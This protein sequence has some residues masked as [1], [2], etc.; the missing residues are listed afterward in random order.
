MCSRLRYGRL[1]TFD[2]GRG[3]STRAPAVGQLLN[4]GRGT[5]PAKPAPTWGLKLADCR[6]AQRRAG[7]IPRQ[8]R[9]A[10][11]TGVLTEVAVDIALS[12]GG[13]PFVPEFVMVTYWEDEALVDT[14]ALRNEPDA[15]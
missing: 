15:Q 8:S 13:D 12:S 5:S 4:E 2:K 7:N 10:L 3:K 6:L 14:I 9:S 1:R 11:P